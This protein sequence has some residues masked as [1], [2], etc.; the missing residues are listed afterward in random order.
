MLDVQDFILD[1]KIVS[2]STQGLSFCP[3]AWYRVYL[4][5]DTLSN[6]HVFKLIDAALFI[7]EV[8]FIWTVLDCF[9]L[10]LGV[11]SVSYYA[12]RPVCDY[13]AHALNA[14][15]WEHTVF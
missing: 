12:S 4:I 11:I 13:I 7:P 5:L 3:C 15:P 14:R 6:K 8:G 1:W 2:L 9:S 10:E